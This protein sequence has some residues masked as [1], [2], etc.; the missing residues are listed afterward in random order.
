MAG[1]IVLDADVPTVATMPHGNLLA[2]VLAPSGDWSECCDFSFHCVSSCLVL[3][4]PIIHTLS[5]QVKPTP[6]PERVNP[7]FSQKFL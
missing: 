1:C 4:A 3:Y 5:S 7:E 6:H 2:V